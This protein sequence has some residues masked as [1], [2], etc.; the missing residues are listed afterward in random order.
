M[1]VAEVRS[2]STP[3]KGLTIEQ[4]AKE[5]GAVLDS[6]P[7]EE[8]DKTMP[9]ILLMMAKELGYENL[10]SSIQEAV[11]NVLKACGI[12]PEMNEEQVALCV[13]WYCGQLRPNQNLILGIRE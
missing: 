9:S 2:V 8:V 7:K 6:F 12:K 3:E 4:V 13:K 1:S 10:D 5:V 11:Q